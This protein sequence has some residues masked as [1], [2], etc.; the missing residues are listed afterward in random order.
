MLRVERACTL[1]RV[2]ESLDE[3]VQ[4]VLGKRLGATQ[5]MRCIAL[6]VS[7]IDEGGLL[8]EVQHEPELEAGVRNGEVNPVLLSE[9][10]RTLQVRM[11]V[12]IEHTPDIVV[13][14]AAAALLVGSLLLLG[15]NGVFDELERAAA[16]LGDT[17]VGT[18]SMA[19]GPMDDVVLLGSCPFDEDQEVDCNGSVA[20]LSP[21][22]T[23]RATATQ[24][25]S[26]ALMRPAA[27][28]NSPRDRIGVAP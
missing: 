26:P 25:R 16:K 4:R 13:G 6:S 3:G 22:P 9:L 10:D 23:T 8:S 20:S 2:R 17:D 14:T 27:A 18:V 21:R 1:R 15:R 19:S 5:E 12:D 28:S 7:S 24:S 11:L